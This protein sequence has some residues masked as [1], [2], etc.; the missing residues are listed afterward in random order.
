MSAGL[1]IKS[2]ISVYKNAILY[3]NATFDERLKGR[4]AMVDNLCKRAKTK[5]L[6]LTVFLVACLVL[7]GCAGDTLEVN[8]NTDGSDGK[9]QL[10]NT[11]ER[12]M[13][14]E[15]TRVYS[16]HY[17]ILDL[18]MK[19][20]QETGNTATFFYTMTFK[21]FDRDPDTVQY[22]IDAKNNNS[23][24]YEQMKKEYLEP[25]EANYEFKAE[26]VDGKILLYSNV[27][28]KGIEWERTEVSDFIM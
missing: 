5:V 26:L 17:E 9:S 10:Y 28:P 2:V 14:D 13:S 19:N 25:K 18:D 8:G 20:W 21:N 4:D 11:V 7:A 1:T 22:I 3:Q 6:L 24:Y 15:F 12:Y 23:P 16:P 27:S